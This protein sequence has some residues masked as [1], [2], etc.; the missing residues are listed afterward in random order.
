MATIFEKISG[1]DESCG[2]LRATG[3]EAIY[4]H[5]ERRRRGVD[6]QDEVAGRAGEDPNGGN[7][8]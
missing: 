8:A 7:D 1:D 3:R 6:G 5:D 2:D 4:I